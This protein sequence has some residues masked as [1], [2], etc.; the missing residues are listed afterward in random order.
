MSVKKL[1]DI[2]V[3]YE[4]NGEEVTDKLAKETG[5]S[6]GS[7]NWFTVH[8]CRLLTY[9]KRLFYSVTWFNAPFEISASDSRHPVDGSLKI[10]ATILTRLYARPLLIVLLTPRSMQMVPSMAS[11]S[12]F[13]EVLREKMVEHPRRTKM[14]WIQAVTPRGL[15]SRFSSIYTF[16]DETGLRFSFTFLGVPV[17]FALAFGSLKTNFSLLISSSVYAG[18][19]YLM[20][21]FYS[22]WDHFWLASSLHP[23][24]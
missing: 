2:V 13:S 23:G 17:V 12:L 24:L 9:G 20:F 8:E 16:I 18:R 3:V 22:F 7:G 6:H 4:A 15:I 1:L 14:L 21:S 19:M 5:R 10:T 11:I